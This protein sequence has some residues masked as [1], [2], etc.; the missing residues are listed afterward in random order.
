MVDAMRLKIMASRS[1]SVFHNDLP[2][3]S[4]VDRGDKQPG[5]RQ[6]GDLISLHFSFRKISRLK[7]NVKEVECDLIVGA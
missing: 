7:K 5:S 2:T 4:K 1:P 6:C 3:G